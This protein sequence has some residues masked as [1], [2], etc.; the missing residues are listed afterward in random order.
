MENVFPSS[1]PLVS[2]KL[3]KLRDKGT[4]IPKIPWLEKWL[5]AGVRATKDMVLTPAAVKHRWH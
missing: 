4:Q 5:A 1:H 3:T 2:H